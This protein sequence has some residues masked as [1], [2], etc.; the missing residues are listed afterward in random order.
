[1]MTFLRSQ[2]QAVLIIILVVLGGS[3]IFYGTGNVLTS[4]S[5]GGDD[6]G[7]IDGQS[8]SVAELS[9]AV[10]LTRDGLIMAG[11]SQDLAQPGV[12]AQVAEAAWVQLLTLHEADR[13]H[14]QI[15]D[16]ELVNYIHDQPLFQKDGAYSPE[17]YQKQMTN[18]ES[19]F[20]ITP[21]AFEDVL[22]NDLRVD[23][24]NGALFNGIRVSAQDVTT[25]YQ[26]FDGLTQVS[27]ITFDPKAFLPTV[28]VTPEAIAAEYKAHP[29]NPAYRTLEKRKVDYVLLSLPPDQAKLPAKDKAAAIE[30]LGEKALDFAIALQPAPSSGTDAASTAAAPDFQT[31]AKAKGFTP[32]TTDF[33]TVETTP[34][35]LPPSPAF[36]SAAFALTKENP[37]SKVVELDNGVA[38]LRLDDI[39]PSD[40]LPL[41]QVKAGIA[42]QLKQSMASDAA[43][44]AAQNAALQLHEALAKGGDFKAVVASLKLPVETMAPFVP[45]KTST[46]GPRVEMIAYTATSLAV[47]DISQPIPV[48]DDNTTVLVHLDSRAV[49]DPKGFADFATK[50]RQNQDERLRNQ[51][52]I[53]WAKWESTR[54]GT[55]KPPNLD[56]YGGAEWGA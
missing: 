21:D 51:V 26:K 54:P 24:V 30:T 2:S 48:Q 49:A 3:F 53:D 34:A 4:S 37:I 38:V 8:L 56:E 20:H 41:E 32:A 33:F 44:K 6:Y 19:R 1:M 25:E 40:L 7:R 47:G 52:Y 9:N 15:S 39:Q 42:D 55:H 17:L 45:T 31:E 12:D 50:F 14:I 22:R 29:E 11:R 10:R 5:A 16:K 28:S 43:Q 23:A 18:L 46:M 13:L 27:V 35:G 36:N